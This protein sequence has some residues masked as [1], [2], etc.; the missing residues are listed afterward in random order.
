MKLYELSQNYL[1]ILELVDNP[2]IDQEIIENALAEIKE[3]I[4]DKSENIVKLIKS[5]EAEEK[6]IKDEENRLADRRKRIAKRRDGLKGYLEKE[7]TATGIDKLTTSLFTIYMQKNPASVN[8]ISERS[9]PAEYWVPQDPRLDK[10]ALAD[11]LKSGVIVPGV[12]L[13]QGRSLRI[14]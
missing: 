3:G 7:L 12:E 14:R 6:A 11:R 2:E 5:L 4:K 10:K 1:N 13:N 8:V 9:I